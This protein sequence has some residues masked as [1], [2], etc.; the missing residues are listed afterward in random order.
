MMVAE[1]AG[2]V[3]IDAALGRYKLVEVPVRRGKRGRAAGLGDGNVK[4]T[5]VRVGVD[6]QVADNE[7]PD[8]I[9][10]DHGRIGHAGPA[11][12]VGQSA[13]GKPEVAERGGNGGGA[14][15]LGAV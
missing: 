9:V 7:P 5:H 12:G 11:V 1:V 2:I 14:R 10:V 15:G 8:L 6:V 13:G 4:G 3:G